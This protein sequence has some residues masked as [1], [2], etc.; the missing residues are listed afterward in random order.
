MYQWTYS[1][2]LQ[3][4][5]L[6]GKKTTNFF[7]KC[8]SILCFILSNLWRMVIIF[9]TISS[10]DSVSK[11]FFYLV[12]LNSEKWVTDK[13][14][15]GW[16]WWFLPVKLCSSSKSQKSTNKITGGETCWDVRRKE[17]NSH[18]APSLSTER[19]EVAGKLQS[20]V[21]PLRSEHPWTLLRGKQPPNCSITCW[22]VLPGTWW[23]QIREKIWSKHYWII[24]FTWQ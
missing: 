10:Q 19:T 13:T 24:S 15:G 7:T 21:S 1:S 16:S 18:I 23:E 4:H 17:L 12:Y 14:E 20:F 6:G 8:F 5:F 11:K 22:V 3:V 2:Y 9:V